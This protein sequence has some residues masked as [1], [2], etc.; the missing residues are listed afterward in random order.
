MDNN[1][2]EELID[3]KLA[4]AKLEVVEKRLHFLM[5][6][7]GAALAVFG[8]AFPLWQSTRSADKVDSALLQM[9]QENAKTSEGIRADSRASAESLERAIPTIRADLRAEMDA[10]SRHLDVASNKVDNAIQDM[11]KQFKELAGTQLRKPNL[12]CL[13]SGSGLDG[14]TIK[15]SPAHENV[16]INVKNSGDAPARSVRMRLYTNLNTN[17]YLRGDYT[18]W[19]DLSKSDEP[20]YSYAFETQLRPIDPKDSLPIDFFIVLSE[21]PNI[22][23]GSYPVLLK[24]FYEQ[25]EPRRYFFTLK[26]TQ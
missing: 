12:E 18:Q 19:F 15:I 9:R 13:S 8:V 22:K 24:V 25:P 10:Q 1:Q 7:A 14:K 20:N 23:P 3:K 4:E 16:R 5:W 21:F 6:L 17:K 26:I 11:H 2:I